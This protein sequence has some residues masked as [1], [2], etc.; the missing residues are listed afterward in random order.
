MRN[1]LA[2]YLHIAAATRPSQTL[3]ASWDPERKST[4]FFDSALDPN[5]P[6][7]LK[8]PQLLSK[9]VTKD[10]KEYPARRMNQT[11]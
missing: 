2:T 10:H 4:V 5:I 1:A 9:T 3:E 6:T 7:F 8:D 11:G